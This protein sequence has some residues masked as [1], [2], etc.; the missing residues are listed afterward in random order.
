MYEKGL[1]NK[2]KW[3]VSSYFWGGKKQLLFIFIRE[4]HEKFKFH[5]YMVVP[6]R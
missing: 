1:N 4:I 3:D 2:S 5:G 6:K